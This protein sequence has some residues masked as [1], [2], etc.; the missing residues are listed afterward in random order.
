MPMQPASTNKVLTTAAALLTL[1]RDATPDHPG[2]WPAG[3]PVW[4][5]CKGGGDPTLS[6]A[7]AGR[8]TWYKGAARIS[9]LADQVRSSGT[10]VT[11][12]AGR[13]WAR[14]AGRRWRRAGIRLDIDGGDIAPMEVGD[15]RRRPHP[16]GDAPESRRST[17]AR[18]W[19]PAAR[20]PP[21]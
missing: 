2:D 13:R 1:D 7:P 10:D 8:H 9:D 11:T 19:T 20:W 12:R 15:A 14:T 3:S 4:S 18:A 6:A 17:H 21:R 5:C 16:A